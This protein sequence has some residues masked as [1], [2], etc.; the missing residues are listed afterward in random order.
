MKTVLNK[1]CSLPK[2]GLLLPFTLL[3]WYSSLSA[4]QNGLLPLLEELTTQIQEVAA[5]KDTYQQSVIIDEERPWKVSFL[6]TKVDKK[7]NAK[8]QRYELN[9]ADANPNLV[10][11]S[12]KKDLLSVA[13]KIDNRQKFIKAYEGSEMKNYIAELKIYA[14]DKDNAAEIQSLLKSAIQLAQKQYKEAFGIPT[15]YTEQVNWLST[16]IKIAEVDG[17]T[18]QQ[19]WEPDMEVAGKF[20]LAIVK[21][22]AKKSSEEVKIANLADFSEHSVKL[23]V[24]AKKMFIELKT[25][26]NRKFIETYKDDELK[27][28]GHTLKISTDDIDH[29]RQVL[30]VLKAAIP[31]AKKQLEAQL[32]TV[33]NLETA[34][35]LLAENVVEVADAKKTF[36][37]KLSVNCV[38]EFAV[39]TTTEKAAKTQKFLFNWADC[40]EKSVEIK[41]AAKSISLQFKINQG[42]KLIQQ[43]KEEEQGNYTNQIK[44]KAG[45]I[46]NARLLEYL[47]PKTIELC[48]QQNT[49]SLPTQNVSE[50]TDWLIAKIPTITSGS[51]EYTQTLE[52][53]EDDCKL[54][55][56]QIKSN[57]KKSSDLIWEFNNRDLDPEAIQFHISGKE[58]AVEVATRYKEKSIK[59]YKNG[60]PSDYKSGFKILLG[61]VEDTRAIIEVWKEL[62]KL[63]Q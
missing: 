60:D 36:T 4:Q 19:S 21:T 3:F 24:Q 43:F 20:R 17:K 57:D 35:V 33:D 32:P 40:N 26:R 27:S 34:L 23:V 42:K 2:V 39:T 54:R 30:E 31:Q 63:C 62:V 29:S 55:F 12:S 5:A 14:S 53:I 45:D 49:L 38:T 48:R 1:R 18:I 25:R 47:L 46:E 50:A 51:N 56:T 41:T 7:G 15:D 11:W 28:L 58:I 59:H 61:N 52:R 44:I 10:R 13:V 9:L 37:Q 22:D 6:Q 8:E 16:N